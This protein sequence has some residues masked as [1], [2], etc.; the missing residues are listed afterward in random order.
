MHPERHSNASETTVAI[1]ETCRG[2]FGKVMILGSNPKNRN[3]FDAALCHAFSQLYGGQRFINRVKRA[4]EQ[5]SLLTRN[6]RDAVCFPQQANVNER[7]FVCA[8]AAIHSFQGIAQ[9]GPICFVISKYAIPAFRKIVMVFDRFWIKATKRNR[10]A[11][12]IKEQAT[13]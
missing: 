13:L 8:P 1:Y 9:C 3:R 2:D 4:A 7:P 12:V 11:Q 10:I 5:P 6:N